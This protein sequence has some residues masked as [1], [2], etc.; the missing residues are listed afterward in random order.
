MS[1]TSRGP[2]LNVADAS[3][4]EMKPEGG[5]G[6]FGAM[7]HQIGQAIGTEMIGV[8]YIVVE[9]G[10]RAFP[11]HNHLANE[12]LFVVLEGSGTYRFGEGEFPVRAGDVCAA[13]KGGPAKARQMVNTGAGPLKYLAISTRIDPDV[14]EYPDSGKYAVSAIA[15]GTGWMDPHLRVVG[16]REDSLGYWEG[17]EL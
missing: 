7:L 10:K 17:E 15:P 2:V 6:R 13:P 3:G 4:F 9:P 11:F 5:T 1:D 14:V 8:N 16:R 12:E